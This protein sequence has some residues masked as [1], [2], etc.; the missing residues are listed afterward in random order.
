MIMSNRNYK[1]LTNLI[2]DKKSNMFQG[3]FLIRF[4]SSIE[5]DADK[6]AKL[7]CET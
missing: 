7:I 2:Y 1:S 5:S 3:V 4:G 6:V